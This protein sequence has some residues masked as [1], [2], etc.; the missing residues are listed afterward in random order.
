[1]KLVTAHNVEED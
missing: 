1:M